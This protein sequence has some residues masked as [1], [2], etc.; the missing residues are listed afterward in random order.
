MHKSEYTFSNKTVACYFDA[1]FSSLDE[2]CWR[3]RILSSLQM[4]MFMIIMQQR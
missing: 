3:M 1:E 4:K 2:T